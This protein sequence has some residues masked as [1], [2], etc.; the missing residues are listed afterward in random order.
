[1]ATYTIWSRGRLLGET[2]LGFVYRPDRI[3][4]GWFLPNELGERLMPMACGVAPAM[5]YACTLGPDQNLAADVL[6]ASDQ[7]EALALELRGPDGRVIETEDVGIVDTEYLL[8]IPPSE[9]EDDV[10]LTAEEQ[11]ELDE[12]VAEW[13]EM[14]AEEQ[15][16]RG[17]PD[18]GEDE[19][20]QMPRYQ[21]QVYL[22]DDASVP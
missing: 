16:L 14:L 17:T 1:M 19:E 4:Y 15:L 9:D 21:I 2:D 7:E 12:T 8:S 6:A 20:T 13:D 22:V 5:R 3:R 18:A 11:A 10:Q